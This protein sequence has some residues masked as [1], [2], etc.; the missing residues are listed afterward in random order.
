MKLL[1]N[2]LFWKKAAKFPAKLSKE[3][4]GIFSKFGLGG[5]PKGVMY[6]ISVG[7]I[8]LAVAS[9]TY[10]VFCSK[11]EESGSS[12]DKSKKTKVHKN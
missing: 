4:E 1:D 6:G 2:V 5:L 12:K 8:A 3:I 9:A 7:L 10:L 11:D